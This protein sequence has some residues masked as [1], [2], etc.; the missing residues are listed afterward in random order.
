[1]MASPIAEAKSNLVHNRI[2]APA[3]AAAAATAATPATAATAAT[4]ATPAGR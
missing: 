1:M 3:F 4:P 2:A